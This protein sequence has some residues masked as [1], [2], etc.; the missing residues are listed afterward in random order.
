M[1]SAATRFKLT[2]VLN[3]DQS[4]RRVSLAGEVDGSDAVLVVERAPF[5]DE[6]SGWRDW[7]RGWG[8]LITPCTKSHVD[9]YT[10][11]PIRSVTETPELY[12]KV[13]R[14]L[15]QRAREGGRLNWVYNILD[16]RSEVKDVI[17]RTPPYH[18][19]DKAFVLL[20]DLNWD[21][22]TVEALHLLAL[23]ERRDLWSL[24][25]LRKGHVAWL[26]DMRASLVAA[27]VSKYPALEAHQ[28]KLYLHYQP[29]YYHLHI[30]IVHVAL[31]AGASQ[32]GHGR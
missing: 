28:L 11:Q 30:H 5:S 19:K 1:A 2:S 7:R 4:G 6:G 8:G 32:A 10:K 26:E 29:T 21:R 9:K 14:P 3:Q 25:D 31:E 20:P 18:D 23:V 27:T 24:R 13:I 22:A 15:M 17:Y 16:G 12:R